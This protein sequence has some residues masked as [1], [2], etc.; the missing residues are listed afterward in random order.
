MK[1]SWER[2]LAQGRLVV[3]EGLDWQQSLGVCWLSSQRCQASCWPASCRFGKQN[4]REA[5]W[6]WLWRRGTDWDVCS[7]LFNTAPMYTF[8]NKWHCFFFQNYV[9]Q[10]WAQSGSL[11]LL[12]S[13]AR[14][15]GAWKRP[16]V[17]P[18]YPGIQTHT[19]HPPYTIQPGMGAP[20]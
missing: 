14:K 12:G 3:G 1:A 11:D 10:D 4:L 9:T 20:L 8:E 18:M 17:V 15:V 2:L 13:T 6:R 19:R 5:T 7:F 16:E